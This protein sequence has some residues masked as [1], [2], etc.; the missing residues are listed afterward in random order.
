MT[1]TLATA[2][3]RHFYGD[4]PIFRPDKFVRDA[5]RLLKDVDFDTV[6]GTGM[7][8]VPAATLIGRSMHKHVLLVRKE[9]DMGNHHDTGGRGFVGQLGARWIFV[10]DFMS[11]G[12]TFRR[13]YGVVSA[14]VPDYF[15]LGDRP[16]SVYAGAYLFHGDSGSEPEFVLP[17]GENLI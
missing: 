1:T 2:H 3:V 13:V 8:G 4:L 15:G 14:A 12:A 11:S 5:R 16:I 17:G 10:D 6:V 9:D 7:S